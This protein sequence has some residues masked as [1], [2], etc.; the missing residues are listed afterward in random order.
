LAKQQKKLRTSAPELPWKS[1]QLSRNV[2]EV[3]VPFQRNKGWE[4]WCLLQSDHHLDN[5]HCD[6]ALVREH[7]DQAVERQAAVCMGGDQMCLMQGRFDPRGSKGDIR[8]EHVGPNYLDRVIST[9]AEFF[10]PYAN[11]IVFMGCGNHE[12]SV[13][14]RL[15]S[16]PHER[17]LGVINA[18]TG[19]S[20]YNG[21]YSSFTRFAFTE[22]KSGRGNPII[23]SRLLHNDHGAGG[24]APV[25]H[26][27]I[28]QQR[29]AVYLPD[30]D[31]VWSGHIHRSIHAEFV[32]KRV[33]SKGT[34]Y[35]DT[36]LHLITTTYKEEY[37][38]GFDGYHAESGREPRPLG[39]WW[40]RFYWSS[41]EDR[42]LFEAV[43]AK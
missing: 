9:T 38:D 40:V 10:S 33:T 11:N 36:Q 12:A 41:K 14:R 21:G 4:F 22:Y 27:M 7:L 5:P 16:H 20:I 37:Q 18:K 26:G 13:A 43:R 3:R 34:V 31:I 6:Q 25:T 2:F 17:M 1:S 28:G 24:G 30:A 15:E 23:D 19:S 8:P 32:R 35:L 42:V 39:G 29:R